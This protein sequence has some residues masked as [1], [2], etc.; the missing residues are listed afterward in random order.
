VQQPHPP[1]VIG[2]GGEQRTLRVVVQHANIWNFEVPPAE[3]FTDAPVERFQH[4]NVVLDAHCAA[5]GREPAEIERSVQLFA[6]SPTLGGTRE[7][8]ERFVA[9]GATHLILLLRAP[10]P[11]GIA[12]HLAEEVMEPLLG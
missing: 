4:K 3:M 1:L 7:M 12:R 10:Y 9:A 2:G 11:V 5:I 6:D 8:L